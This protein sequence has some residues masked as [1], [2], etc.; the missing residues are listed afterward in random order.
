MTSINIQYKEKLPYKEVARVYGQIIS[1]SNNVTLYAKDF[2]LSTIRAILLTPKSP[3]LVHIAGSINSIGSY[4]NYV[5]LVGSPT[6][7]SWDINFMV[8][9]E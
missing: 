4:D 6:A 8:I 1:G 9:G 5:K 3:A 7:G 2:E